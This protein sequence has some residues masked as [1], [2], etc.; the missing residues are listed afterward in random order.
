MPSFSCITCIT[1]VHLSGTR[2]VVYMFC[3]AFIR[4]QSGAWTMSRSSSAKE[5]FWLPESC[6]AQPQLPLGPH[7]R[8]QVPKTCLCLKSRRNQ[9]LWMESRWRLSQ[10][11]KC[12]HVQHLHACYTAGA[13]RIKDPA[14]DD[15]LMQLLHG[16]RCMNPE[17]SAQKP[18]IRTPSPKSSAKP[19]SPKPAEPSPKAVPLARRLVICLTSEHAVLLLYTCFRCCCQFHLILN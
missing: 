7:R 1:E 8:A 17:A 3:P 11:Q 18:G 9:S 5:T 6:Q 14:D 12:L 16:L 15:N 19:P 4:R 13:F 2:D 10:R